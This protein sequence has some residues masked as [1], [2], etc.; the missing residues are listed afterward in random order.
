M[1]AEKLQNKSQK[2]VLYMSLASKEIVNDEEKN[3]NGQDSLLYNNR[4]LSLDH[5]FFL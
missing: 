1:F 3:T 5:I 2:S 4:I